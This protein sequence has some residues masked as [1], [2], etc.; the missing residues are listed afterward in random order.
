MRPVFVFFLTGR[1][2]DASEASVDGAEVLLNIGHDLALVR[3]G[4]ADDPDRRE[5]VNPALPLG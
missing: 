5:G 3:E 4:I 1:V 2:P